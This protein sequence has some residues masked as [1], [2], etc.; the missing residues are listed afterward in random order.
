[1]ATSEN[2]PIHGYHS[3]GH[4]SRENVRMGEGSFG[5]KLCVFKMKGNKLLVDMKPK[6]F[7]V[8]LWGCHVSIIFRIWHLCFT[9]YCH[10]AENR[11]GQS[12][13]NC[14][15]VNLVTPLGCA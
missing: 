4:N 1:M 10:H 14:G 12:L 9:V 13:Q 8:S 6:S 2:T 11:I 7:V 5:K 3:L 15:L